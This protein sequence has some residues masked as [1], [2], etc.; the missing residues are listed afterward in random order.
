MKKIAII[1]GGV[2]GL[3]SLYHLK[4]HADLTLYEKNDYIGGHAHTHD[5][6]DQVGKIVTLDTGFLVCNEHTYPEF[7]KMLHALEVPYVDTEMSFAF[8]NLQTDLQ[9]GGSNLKQLFVQ[10]KNIFSMQYWKFI[11]G[12][13]RFHKIG[14]Q[15]ADTISA[16]FTLGEF[17]DQYGISEQTLLNYI[18]PVTSA[19]WS[20]TCS[21]MRSF[22]VQNMLIF[23]KNH[24]LL[25]HDTQ[26]Q[27]KTLADKSRSYV[28]AVLDHT[29]PNIQKNTAVQSVLSKKDGVEVIHE[30]G[31][32]RYDAVI[33]AA[34]ADQ[35]QHLVH[36][37]QVKDMLSAFEYT[38]NIAVLH[39]DSSVM[40]TERSIW[41][42]WNYI[43]EKNTLATQTSTVY[44]LNALQQLDTETQFFVSINPF[45]S[46]DEKHIIKTMNYSHPRFSVKGQHMQTHLDEL[47]IN[48]HIQF[49]G[50][51]QRYGFHEDGW[52]SGKRASEAILFSL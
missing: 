3:S 30:Q 22:P 21:D 24:G 41:S 47:H 14:N 26:F 38:A 7:I 43:Q 23:M 2:S 10:P 39:T 44:W 16:D 11:Y 46:I 50:A 5:I 34:H 48:N 27:W 17:V 1:G 8:H 31:S 6:Q 28:E 20:T 15:V 9:Y 49:A 18:I 35:A 19:V 29:Q 33:V 32:E 4:D 51:Y 12:I 36:D 13:Y 45:Q 40:P 52:I 42:A 25:G 37:A